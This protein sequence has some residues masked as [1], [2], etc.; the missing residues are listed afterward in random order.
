MS[1]KIE[2]TPLPNDNVD[3]DDV[4]D[5]DDDD[6]LVEGVWEIEIMPWAN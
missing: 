5:D 1:N 4:V 2:I 3:D 6:E